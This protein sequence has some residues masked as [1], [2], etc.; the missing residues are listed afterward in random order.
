MSQPQSA[1]PS[2]ASV[3][4]NAAIL[5]GNERPIARYDFEGGAYVRVAASGDIDT[6]AALDMVQ[7]L[8]DLKRA[9][10]TRKKRD[11]YVATVIATPTA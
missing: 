9:E 11:G 3:P 2:A 8:I 10:L 1:T 4:Q 7:T 5:A 6:E